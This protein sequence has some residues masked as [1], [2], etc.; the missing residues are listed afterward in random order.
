MKLVGKIIIKGSLITKTGLHIGGSKSSLNI[1]TIDN[2]VIKTALDVPYVP[3]SSIKGKL[4]SLLAKVEGSLFF[5]DE[6]RK[7][8]LKEIEKRMT[9][10]RKEG[11][12]RKVTQLETYNKAI[13]N[14]ATDEGCDNIIELFGYSGDST[15][16]DKILLNRL[17]VRDAFLEN[18]EADIFKDGYTGSKWENVI[19]RKTGTALNPRQTERVPVQA[20][21][22]LELVYNIYD[23]VSSDTTKFQRH[24]QSLLLAL[25]LLQDDGLGGNISR[26]YGQVKVAIK[27]VLYKQINRESLQYEVMESPETNQ[28]LLTEFTSKFS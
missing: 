20:S 11:N 27:E 5:S 9:K 1:G 10:E 15:N 21:F 8:E 28:S 7:K 17:L 19:D 13:G 4:R 14:S 16:K 6:D 24:I 22:G 18:E 2:N 23:D 25:D 3:G 26:G 12:N